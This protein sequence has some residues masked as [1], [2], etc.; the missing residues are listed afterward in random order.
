MSQYFRV[1]HRDVVL[2]GKRPFSEL[3][4]SLRVETSLRY[5]NLSR[6]LNILFMYFDNPGD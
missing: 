3:R 5:Q 4:K 6:C 1:L 2:E